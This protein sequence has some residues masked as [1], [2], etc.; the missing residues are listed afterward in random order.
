MS[1]RVFL[2]TNLW[3][4]LYAKE[5][6]VKYLKV[7]KIIADEFDSIHLSTQTLGELF[8]VLTRKKMVTDDEAREIILELVSSFPVAEIETLKV[9]QALEI[10]SRYQYSYWD[11][12]IIATAL[13]LDCTILYSEDLHHSQSVSQKMIIVNPFL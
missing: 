11:S 12:L 2:D 5:P 8:N 9:I 13:V 4:Y 1:G 7:R 3:V 6:E 10:K